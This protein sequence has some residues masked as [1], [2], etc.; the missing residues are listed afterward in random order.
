MGDLTAW[1]APRDDA[2][3]QHRKATFQDIGRVGGNSL[4]QPLQAAMRLRILSG[5][6]QV[7]T[8]TPEPNQPKQAR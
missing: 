7:S 3:V 4:D 5:G 6:L 1:L 8:V 2:S